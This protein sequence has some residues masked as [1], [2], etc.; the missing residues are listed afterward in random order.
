MY[1]SADYLAPN[2][3]LTTVHR[4]VAE[5]YEG[6]FYIRIN[7]FVE[8]TSKFL[9]WQS[10]ITVNQLADE[11]QAAAWLVSPDGLFP[12]GVITP[13]PDPIE[14]R[15]QEMH[16][17]LKRYRDFYIHRGCSTPHGIVDTDEVS[18]R[19]ISAAAQSAMLAKMNSQPFSIEW[20]FE[21]NS[22]VPLNVDEMIAMGSRVSQLVDHCYHRSWEIQ[23]QID[24]AVTELEINL[25]PIGTGWSL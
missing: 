18:L 22:L 20:R 9:V 1:I 11:D 2:G 12:N 4:F 6:N 23:T 10:Q 3:V 5:E 17:L 14:V 7:S 24:S 25:I 16:N 8:L 19:N 15:R 13:D 21:D